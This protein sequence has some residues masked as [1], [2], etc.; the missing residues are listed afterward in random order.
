MFAAKRARDPWQIY[1]AEH[2]QNTRERLELMEDLRD[3]IQRGQI[4]LYYQPIFDL[5]KGAVIGAEALARWQHPV[6]GILAPA[7]FLGLVE[8]AGLMGHFTVACSTRRSPNK[9]TG[10]SGATTWAL[11]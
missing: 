8:D 5:S 7:R 9:L 6:H 3:A 11:R 1:T 2:D 4:V 10:R